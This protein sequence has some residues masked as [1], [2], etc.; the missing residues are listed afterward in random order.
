MKDLPVIVIG[1]SAGGLDALVRL[2][3][4]LPADLGAAIFVVQHLAPDTSTVALLRGI[5]EVTAIPCTEAVDG[6]AIEAGHIYL[7]R[8]DHHLLLTRGRM[9]L[10]KGARE[11]RSRPGIDPLFRSAAVAYRSR[12]IGVLLTGYLD[13]GTAGLGAIQRCGGVCVV[14]DPEDAAYPDMPQNAL[15]Q[16]KVD[17]VVPLSRMGAL[18]ARLVRRE[19]QPDPPVPEDVAIEAR[20]A[21]RVLSDLGSVDALGEQVPF[22]CPN[23]GGV[24]WKMAAAKG[25]RYRCHTGHSFTSS[26]LLAEQSARIEE[27]LWI[28]LRMFEE[29]R[30][31]LRTISQRSR[32][33]AAKSASERASE[34]EKHIQRIRAMLTA[35]PGSGARSR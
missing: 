30:N 31:L 14:Q 18:L 10:T 11:N 21:E 8:A 35:S 1:T 13:D 3:G 6:A 5:G 16:L 29:R 24:L 25:D 17:H 12:V 28:A 34:S 4:Q 33:R 27:T 32:G 2:M 19:R 7:A 26:V 9:R 22:N 15:H 23:C 20:I